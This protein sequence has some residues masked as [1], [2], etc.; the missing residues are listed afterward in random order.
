M[1]KHC[2][3]IICIILLSVLIPAVMY[4]FHF[5]YDPGYYDNFNFEL[6]IPIPKP[7]KDTIPPVTNTTPINVDSLFKEL[8]H[9]F[10]ELISHDPPKLLCPSPSSLTILIILTWL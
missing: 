9:R 5:Y 2:M 10:S 8:S 6:T 7:V 1:P 4:S 3:I